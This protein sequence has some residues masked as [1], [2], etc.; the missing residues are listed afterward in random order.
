LS[1]DELSSDELGTVPFRATALPKE[2][3][4]ALGLAGN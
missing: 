1:S 3:A 4:G 2:W